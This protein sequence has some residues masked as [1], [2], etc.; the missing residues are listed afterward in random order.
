MREVPEASDA[1]DR[2]APADDAD[3]QQAEDEPS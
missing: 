3:A 2:A 1:H